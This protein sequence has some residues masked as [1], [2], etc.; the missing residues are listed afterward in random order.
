MCRW[1][2]N[3]A[4]SRKRRLNAA[5]L[6]KENTQQKFKIQKLEQALREEKKK[7]LEMAKEFAAKEEQ[8][9]ASQTMQGVDLDDDD[10]AFANSP[11]A[12]IED[13]EN[14]EEI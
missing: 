2:N 4:I 12:E 8:Y 9:M 11:L 6:Q 7:N 14:H 10:D 3:A 5:G 13:E 1:A